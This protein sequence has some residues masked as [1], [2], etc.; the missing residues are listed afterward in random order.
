[1]VN[2]QPMQVGISIGVSHYQSGWSPEQWLI[3]ADRAMLVT[4]TAASLRWRSNPADSAIN[5]GPPIMRHIIGHPRVALYCHLVF[6]RGGRQPKV[7]PRDGAGA[8]LVSRMSLRGIHVVHLVAVGGECWE[9]A[10][11]FRL[12]SSTTAC[13]CS[14]AAEIWVDRSTTRS[15]SVN[16]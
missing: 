16:T 10:L 12:M 15:I 7:C 13:C 8:P 3:Q 14:A 1:M 2:G 9:M 11:T 4:R 5:G 6:A